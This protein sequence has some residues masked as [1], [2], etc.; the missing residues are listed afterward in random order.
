VIVREA[1]VPDPRVVAADA[2]VQ[3]AAQLLTRPNVRSVLV[4]DGERL[5]GVVTAATLVAAVASGA[6]VRG[7]TARDV[8][9]TE[10]AT[11]GPDGLIDDAL[12]LMAEADLER[13]PVV[14]NGRLLGILPREPLVRRLAEDEAP[15][16]SEG[17]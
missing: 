5:V 9:D 14:E 13:L 12:H 11:I 8:C 7:L 16:E 15:R 6:D 17:S 4:V 2:G 3:E 1:L 10:V